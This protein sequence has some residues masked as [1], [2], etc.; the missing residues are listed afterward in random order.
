LRLFAFPPAGRAGGGAGRR[1]KQEREDSGAEI[2]PRLFQAVLSANPAHDAYFLADLK[3]D[4][5]GWVEARDDAALLESVKSGRWRDTEGFETFDT[6]MEFP[7]GNRDP[8]N[9]D[10]Q[11]LADD[12]YIVRSYQIDATVTA[13]A[14]LSRPRGSRL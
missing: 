7:A 3:T 2:L 14:E 1:H 10:Q 13:G 5:F 11:P 6:W 8:L 12:D 4:H 9:V